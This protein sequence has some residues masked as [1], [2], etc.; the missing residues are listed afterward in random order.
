[1]IFIEKSKDFSADQL[2]KEF[3]RKEVLTLFD[4]I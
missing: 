4:E 3:I 1:M 2:E